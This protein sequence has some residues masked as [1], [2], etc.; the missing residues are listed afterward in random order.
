MHVVTY[1]RM[2]HVRPKYPYKNP[3]IFR[4]RLSKKL[5]WHSAHMSMRPNILVPR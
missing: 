1:K 2:K 4:M 5:M 3:H